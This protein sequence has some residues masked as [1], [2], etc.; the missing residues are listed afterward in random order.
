MG[1]KDMEKRTGHDTRRIERHGG[2][3]K[4]SRTGG[5]G[6][7]K[8]VA[9]RHPAIPEDVVKL[10]LSNLKWRTGRARTLGHGEAKPASVVYESIPQDVVELD[11]SMFRWKTGGSRKGGL[12]TAGI[13]TPRKGPIPEHAAQLDLDMLMDYE[14]QFGFTF[15]TYQMEL[16]NCLS[17]YLFPV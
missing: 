3:Y 1:G 9:G 7:A 16:A 10:D 6:K 14:R 11:L 17:D 13:I 4:G 5:H 15:P 12:G 8:P 2:M